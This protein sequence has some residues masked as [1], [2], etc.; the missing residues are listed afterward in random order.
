[1]TQEDDD[2]VDWDAVWQN[3]EMPADAEP[4]PKQGKKKR[5]KKHH[6]FRNLILALMLISGLYCIL[7][8]SNIPLIAKWRSIYIE[9]AMSTMT[10]QWLATA[11]IPKS[12]IDDVMGGRYNLDEAQTGLITRWGVGGMSQFGKQMPWESDREYFERVYHELDMNSFDSYVKKNPE[13]SRDKDGNIFID[14][15]GLD[16][17]GTSIKTK[18]GDEVLAVD[19]VNGIVIVR[20]TGEGFV[21]RL[22]IVKDPSRVGIGLAK[23][24]G[25]I[26]GGIEKIANYNDAILAINASGFEDPDGTGNGGKAY[27]LVKSNGK[28]YQKQLKTGNKVI[29]FDEKNRLH[30]G[31]YNSLDSFRD[32]VEFKPALIINGEKLVKG[33][34]GWGIQP[35]SAIGQSAKGE[36][37]MLIVDGRAPG[38]SIGCTLGDC[39]DIMERYGAVQACNLD[40]G[41]SSI[42][43][44]N[45]REISRPSAANK[46][47][48][49]AIPNGFMVFKK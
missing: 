47:K 11:L 3:D 15:A 26:G 22:A 31:Q 20:V 1:Q 16:D 33:S 39:A 43:Y 29:A 2:F 5:K 9:T 13:S 30:I 17:G 48:G 19:T 40:G 37:L 44:Y 35:R 41:S 49:R 25:E 24:F 4:L 38:Y 14:K 32:A 46:V 28:Q 7:V 6:V 27:G 34:A 42:M 23:N 8:F 12:V 21:G 10:H 45:G 18:S 36:V